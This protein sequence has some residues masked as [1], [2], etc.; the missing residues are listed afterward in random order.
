MPSTNS[1]ATIFAWTGALRKRGELDGIT[2]LCDFANKLEQAC[3]E[4]IES[5]VMTKSLSILSTIENKRIV[6]GKELLLC[7]KER[8]DQLLA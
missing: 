8:L 7:I 1:V 2:E 5:G 6:D 4:T 3:I